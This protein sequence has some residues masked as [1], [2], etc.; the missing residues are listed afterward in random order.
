M[1]AQQKIAKHNSSEFG[2]LRPC[3]RLDRGW[4][5]SVLREVP[6]KD[7][8]FESTRQVEQVDVEAYRPPRQGQ[9]GG[10]SGR[11]A[12]RCLEARFRHE[13]AAGVETIDTAILEQGAEH[14]GGPGTGAYMMLRRGRGKPRPFKRRMVAVI[15]HWENDAVVGTYVTAPEAFAAIRQLGQRTRDGQWRCTLR[16]VKRETANS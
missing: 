12:W 6:V 3:I 9:P 16:P 15:D 7:C 8:Q 13:I 10:Q 4:A 1:E 11:A 2:T 14:V 5:D